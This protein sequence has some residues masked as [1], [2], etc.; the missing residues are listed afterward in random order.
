MDLFV[1]KKVLGALL[2]PLPIISLLIVVALCAFY[3][4]RKKIALTSGFFGL[5]LFVIVSTP[6]LPNLLLREIEHSHPQ[7]D[8]STSVKKI[9]ILGCGHVNDGTLPITSQIRPCS[10]IRITEAVRIFQHNPNAT[11]VTSGDSEKHEFSNAEMNSRMLIAL[12]VPESSI[13]MVNKSRDTE[14]ES[15]NLSSVLGKA[16]FALVTSASHMERA[17][18]L[19]QQQRLSPIPAPTEHLVREDNGISFSGLLPNSKHITKAER[20]WYETLGQT[21]LAIRQWFS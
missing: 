17:V 16:P 21:W 13:I 3:F 18:N 8:L 10:L 7:F 1:F 9:V 4:N 5:L 6:I 12:G 19:F 2:M 15:E 20:W 11:I 14:E